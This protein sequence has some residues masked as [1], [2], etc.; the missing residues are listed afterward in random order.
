MKPS[1][2]NP[3]ITTVNQHR[4]GLFPP[5]KQ[6]SKNV[7]G[8]SVVVTNSHGSCTLPEC[9]ITQV[10]AGIME[11]LFASGRQV[12]RTDD[13]QIG[14]LVSFPD[15]LRTLGLS[16]RNGKWLMD[17]LMDLKEQL[18]DARINGLRVV[19]NI[20]RKIKESERSIELPGNA[21]DAKLYWV[22]FEAEFSRFYLSDLGIDWRD[23]LPT[24]TQM[25]G[26]SQAVARYCLS[27]TSVKGEVIADVLTS[28]GQKWEGTHAL[29][30]KQKAIRQVTDDAD[31]FGELGVQIESGR[32]LEDKKV[33]Y[34]KAEQD[35]IDL[36]TK[37]AL[38]VR[39]Y[40]NGMLFK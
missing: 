4:I 6:L 22:I 34:E 36:K 9:R 15:V 37:N 38:S 2:K 35:A 29:K 18:V 39:T 14:V 21:T 7:K 30:L 19:S 25:S 33:R 13:G 26:P 10:H 5:V 24:I 17:H 16:P 40:T 31:L 32:K 20:V 28:L 1:D 3:V 27:H 12:N 11:A 23:H 8:K